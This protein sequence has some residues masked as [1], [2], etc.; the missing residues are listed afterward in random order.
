M[1]NLANPL[2]RLLFLQ[3]NGSVLDM[4]QWILDFPSFSI[5]PKVDNNSC[6]NFNE[7]LLNP[8]ETVL[9]PGK[10]AIIWVKSQIY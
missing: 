8:H 3:R 9:Q 4:R 7:P 10:Q 5:Q 1:S 2:M 6:I